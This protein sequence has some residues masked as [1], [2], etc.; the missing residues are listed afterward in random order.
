[1][2]ILDVHTAGAA[3]AWAA[4]R[5]WAE[6]GAGNLSMLIGEQ[7][8]T[9]AGDLKPTEVQLAVPVPALVGRWALVTASGVRFRE[10]QP[11]GYGFENMLCPVKFVAASKAVAYTRQ[12][13]RVTG[14]FLMHS[15]IL[16]NSA[17]HGHQHATCLH[18]HSTVC[19]TLHNLV[20]PSELTDAIMGVHTEMPMVIPRG[21]GFVPILK[22]G[23]IELARAVAHE[24]KKHDAVILARHGAL[25][26]AADASGALDVL[27]V[28][29]KAARLLWME[30]TARGEISG[31]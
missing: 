1:M 10:V 8:D 24:V 25:A 26:V 20:E 14:E 7:S 4:Q 17:E 12:G 15:L 30:R 19:S 27:E 23:S 31:Q 29:E 2:L 22:P 21:V 13:R 18:L 16:N 11:S 9:V 3:C 5:G 28:L 6:G